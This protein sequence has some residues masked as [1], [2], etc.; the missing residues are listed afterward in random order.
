[1][2]LFFVAFSFDIVPKLKEI[3]ITVVFI[4]ILWMC[5]LIRLQP[6]QV[7]DYTIGEKIPKNEPESVVTAG[8]SVDKKTLT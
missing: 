7:C 2:T 6:E 3:L 1:M 4:L 8:G 5:I